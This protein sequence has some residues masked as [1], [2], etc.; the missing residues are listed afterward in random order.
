MKSLL[1][2]VLT[3]L[4]IQ[5]FAQDDVQRQ[6]KARASSNVAEI[7]SYGFSLDLKD[8]VLFRKEYYN[9]RGCITRSESL[10]KLGEITNSAEYV[11]DD[12]D[13]NIKMVFYGKGGAN[14]RT[15][16]YWFAPD[17]SCKR[18]MY[19]DEEGNVSYGQSWYFNKNGQDT[20]LLNLDDH[21]DY[22]IS[23]IK[24]FDSNGKY[25]KIVYFNEKGKITGTSEADLDE[26]GNILAWYDVTKKK[27]TLSIL[28]KYDENNNLIERRYTTVG[29]FY[30]P[31]SYNSDF[32][33]PDAVTNIIMSYKWD[34]NGNKIEQ[35]RSE[36][37]QVVDVVRY[38]VV[39]RG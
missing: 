35:T 30:I 29:A 38:V 16:Y 21:G 1:I 8:S 27:R 19:Y 5:V 7:H 28:F 20:T 31:G 9:E 12:N 33:E 17:G 26:R 4:S 2:F 36:N 6:R 10:D 3:I 39:K 14:P 18:V 32:K 13:N 25:N 34:S 22:Y 23:F 11:Y 24:Y 15:S 37:G